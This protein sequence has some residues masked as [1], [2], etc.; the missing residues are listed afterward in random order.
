MII[1]R[2]E[3][4][5]RYK[6]TDQMGIVHH[7]NYLAWFEIGRTKYIEQ[8][9][10]TTYAEM[11]RKG[12]LLPVTDAYL[13][14][15]KPAKYGDIVYIET[16]LKQYKG[17]RLVFDYTVTSKSG[18]VLATGYTSHGFVDKALKPIRLRNVNETWHHEL[19]KAVKG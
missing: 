8:L 7:S 10:N 12:I 18:E 11:E 16:K 9:L 1:N 2:T 5:V 6:E 14:Y 4:E 3:I 15:K 13:S 19:M 17:I